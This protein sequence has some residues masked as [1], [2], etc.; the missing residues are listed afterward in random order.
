MERPGTAGLAGGQTVAQGLVANRTFKETFYK[1]A[2]VEAGASSK[3]REAS[4]G[5]NLRDCFA[6]QAR[7]FPRGEKFVRI[8]DVNEVVGNAAALGFWKDFAVPMSKWR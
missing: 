6:G 7:V 1:S 3:N 2:Q 8:Q 4:P 5:G